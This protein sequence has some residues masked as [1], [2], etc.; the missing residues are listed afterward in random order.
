M[1]FINHQETLQSVAAIT[2]AKDSSEM[3]ACRIC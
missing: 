3:F 2:E 1:D